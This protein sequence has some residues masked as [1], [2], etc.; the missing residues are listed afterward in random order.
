MSARCAAL[1]VG[2]VRTHVTAVQACLCLAP[3]CQL[4]RA[5]IDCLSFRLKRR[6][7]S[8]FLGGGGGALAQR[9]QK[10]PPYFTK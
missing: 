3:I 8:H 7:S 5:M 6:V 1:A 10:V 4:D 9:N 2:T